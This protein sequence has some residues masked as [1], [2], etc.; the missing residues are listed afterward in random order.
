MT[1]WLESTFLSEVPVLAI[2]D[3]TVKGTLLLLLAWGLAT[4]L[5]RSSAAVRHRIWALGLCGLIALPVLSSSVPGWRLPIAS[6]TSKVQRVSRTASPSDLAP[7]VAEELPRPATGQV[8]LH[9]SAPT[10]AR[11]S[12]PR[13]HTAIRATP[14]QKPPAEG[15]VAE[16]HAN[17]QADTPWNVVNVVVAVWLVGFLAVVLPTLAGLFAHELRRRSAEPVHEDVWLRLLDSL[18]ERFSIRRRVELRR[19]ELCPIPITWGIVRPVV[20]LPANSDAWIEPTRRIVLLHE[21]AHVRR[22]DVAVQL[23][24]RLAVA[25]Y[26]FHPLAWYALRRLRAECEQACDDCVVESGERRGDYAQELLALACSVRR[27]NLAGSFAMARTNTLEERLKGLFDETRSHLPLGR[28]FGRA[29]LG[30]AVAIVLAMAT[31]HLSASLAGTEGAGETPKPAAKSA[32]AEPAKGKARITGR[33]LRAAD[34][35]PAAGA[36]AILLPPPP[37]GQEYYYGKLPLQAMTTDALGRFTFENLPA[38]RYRVWANLGKLTSRRQSTR[39][40]VVIVPDKED[41]PAPVELRLVDGVTLKTHVKAKATGRGIPN[42]TVHIGWSDFPDDATTDRDGLV[43]LQPLTPERLMLEVWADGYA[44]QSRWFNLES[45]RDA[46]AEFL[47]EPGGDLD[48]MVRDASGKPVAGAGLS[49]FVEGVNRQFEYVEADAEGRYVLGHLPLNTALRIGVSKEDYLR[50]DVSTR[51]EQAKQRLDIVLSQRPYGGGVAGV[52]VD[53]EGRPIAGAE[54]ENMGD[55]T[56]D[57]RSTKTG[58][59]GR[60]LLENLFESRYS[61]KEVVVR[62]RGSAPTRVKVPSGPAG[63]P[64]EVEIQLQ[65]GHRLK[66]RVTDDKNRPIEGVNVYFANGNTPN[67]TGGKTVTDKSGWFAFDS[68]PASCPFSFHKEGYSEIANAQF[69]LDGDEEVRVEMVA[70][71][72][73]VGKV[74]D[75]KSGKPVRKFKVQVTFSPKAQQGE[76]SAG[77]WSDLSDP[78]QSYDSP[79]GHFKISGLVFGMPLQVMVSADGYERAVNERVVT[80]R[81]DSGEAQEF[82]LEPADPAGLVNFRGRLLKANGEPAVGAQ[83]RLIAARN[84]DPNQRWAFPFNWDMIET[85][86]IAL[87]SKVVRFI[88]AAT[89]AKGQ[90]NFTGVPKNAEVELV[91]SGKGIAP[92]RAD[93]LEQADANERGALDLTIPSPAR[94]IVTIDRKQ[95]PSV[96]QIQVSH[97]SGAFGSVSLDVNPKPDQAVFEVGDLAQGEYQIHLMSRYERAGGPAGDGGGLT[98]QTLGTRNVTVRPGRTA[99]VEFKQ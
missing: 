3:A 75:A 5:R 30:G 76:P 22:F 93:H 46:E 23:A 7:A 99:R 48:G 79:E 37:R 35:K 90:F 26:W 88:E 41:S 12:A 38:G 70:A 60:F 40:T 8:E 91:W 45:A 1:R 71:G 61:G 72:A 87:N 56:A 66:G 95:F 92:G 84:R 82:S 53:H 62:A 81:G 94:I 96:G 4:F 24:G 19:Y 86:Q 13:P 36:Q 54:L 42:A 68:L 67:S 63:K 80:V 20:L 17:A 64:A 2:V 43:L 69:A 33:A 65:K 73:I 58:P 44:M 28:K 50:K 89:D 47:L 21:L 74:V 52:V 78:G 32:A 51:V 59:D 39:G 31:V 15:L 83:L 55:S 9:R 77:L 29:L 49:A 25:M 85:R 98:S 57:V 27:L 97:A 34:G 11:S 6:A 16:S 14:A 10:T 18:R